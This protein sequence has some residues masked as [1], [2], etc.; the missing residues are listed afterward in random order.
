MSVSRL[1][2]WLK[3]PLGSGEQYRNV[4]QA[5]AAQGLH[6][7]CS[8]ARC[9]NLGECWSSGTATFMILGDV[10]SR[11]CRFCA[12]THGHPT[13]IDKGEPARIADAVRQLRLQ[14]VV[15]TSV[16]RDDLEDGGASEFSE[17]I[18]LL[19]MQSRTVQIEV[20]IPDFLGNE[21]ALR[22]VLD[23]KPDVLNHN[24]ETVPRLYPLIRPQADYDRSL[25]ILKTSACVLGEDRTKS[26]LMVGM[27]ETREELLE[28]F[29]DLRRSGVARLTIGQYLQPTR[30]HLGV[31]RYMTP[32]EFLEIRELAEAMGFQHVA[33]G[34][35]VRSSY[36]AKES[37]PAQYTHDQ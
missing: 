11:N 25:M 35:L 22:V 28:L 6:T 2:P 16:T 23:A 7:V 24:V 36:H 33:S 3:V 31:V 4:R 8:S 10:C 14:Y 30:D 1:P 5:L 26:G 12:V 29:N 21:G 18:R 19:R 17:V 20:L 32:E 13:A 34:P 27:G 9:P 15:I 37:A